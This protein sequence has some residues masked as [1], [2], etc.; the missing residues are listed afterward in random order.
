MKRAYTIFT[1][2]ILLASIIPISI[3]EEHRDDRRTNVLSEAEKDL[4]NRLDRANRAFKDRR[5]ALDRVTLR[6]ATL[7]KKDI[8]SLKDKLREC[9]TI[10]DSAVTDQDCSDLKKRAKSYAINKLKT[11]FEKNS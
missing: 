6:K 8:R 7:M 3:A 11:I 4:R 5:G 1:I 10:Q 9:N 2:L